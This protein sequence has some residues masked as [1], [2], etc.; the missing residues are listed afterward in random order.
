MPASS[1][2][3]LKNPYSTSKMCCVLPGLSTERRG[4][5]TANRATRSTTTRISITSQFCQGCAGSSG[6]T[7][8]ALRMEL[9]APP[10]YWLKTLVSH[11][12]CSGIGYFVQDFHD[13]GRCDDEKSRQ[14]R[15]QA[16]S[17]AFDYNIAGA[18]EKQIPERPENRARAHPGARRRIHRRRDQSVHHPPQAIKI[19]ERQQ[20]AR[21]ESDRRP[22][23]VT[24]QHDDGADD[25][26]ARADPYD[27]LERA[28]V[29]ICFGTHREISRIS[30]MNPPTVHSSIS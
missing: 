30:C 10:R 5:S 15:H 26:Q 13:D 17:Q 1:T 11:S 18:R 12:S 20:R 25:S 16:D 19:Q 14:N 4:R 3:V 7:W 23:T 24:D 21:Q 22:G 8:T 27:P 29:V 9:A 28:I 2:E 6:V